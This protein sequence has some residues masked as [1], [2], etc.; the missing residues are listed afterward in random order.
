MTSHLAPRR[1]ARILVRA[2]LA[3]IP[4]GPRQNGKITFCRVICRTSFIR[5]PGTPRRDAARLEDPVAFLRGSIRTMR[6]SRAPNETG[7]GDGGSSCSVIGT[8]RV[9][10]LG[11]DHSR[12]AW[13]GNPRARPSGRGRDTGRG[14]PLPVPSVHA[15]S[16][17]TVSVA[18][19]PQCEREVHVPG[20]DRD[21]SGRWSIPKLP[22]Q[23][24]CA[25]VSRPL[26]R[27]PHPPAQRTPHP[28]PRGD[29]PADE[30]GRSR[31]TR[32]FLEPSRAEA[33]RARPASRFSAWHSPTR[34]L[35]LGPK[36]VIFDQLPRLPPAPP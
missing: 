35:R 23:G 16:R 27:V 12:R 31:R 20:R 17:E 36:C 28:P 19:G 4:T 33:P 22:S 14:A 34:V 29:R 11:W 24:P 6:D 25:A 8:C 2:C 3:V 10:L 15:P 13:D 5:Q 1:P 9:V 30:T 18:R 32:R 7:P 26:H 21:R